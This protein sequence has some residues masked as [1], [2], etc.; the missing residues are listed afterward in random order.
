MSASDLCVAPLISSAFML[1]IAAIKEAAALLRVSVTASSLL[2]I[3]TYIIVVTVN[4]RITELCLAVS[5]AF[6]RAKC[7]SRIVACFCFKSRRSPSY[8]GSN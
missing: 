7:A 3:L 6:L 2:D 1:K 4:V 8:V 5:S